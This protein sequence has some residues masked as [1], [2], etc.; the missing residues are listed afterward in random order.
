[1]GKISKA[2][3]YLLLISGCVGFF[4]FPKLNALYLFLLLAAFVIALIRKRAG[5]DAKFLTIM[6]ICIVISRIFLSLIVMEARGER[7]TQDE[8]LYSKKAIIKVY[9]GRGIRDPEESFA[10]FFDD[11]DMMNP[12]YG[13]NAY[14]CILSGFYRIFGYQIQ[15]ARLIN[16]FFNILTFLLIFYMART[17]FGPR[18]AKLSSAIFAFFPSVTLWSVSIGTDMM[19]LL[20]IS[21]Y[22][23][24]LIRVLKKIDIMSVIIMIAALSVLISFRGYAV[25]ILV[26]IT[27]FGVFCF[28]L[29]RMTAP[30][31]TLAGILLILSI[32]LIA[33]ATPA[34]SLVKN[35]MDASLR[36]VIIRQ[37]GFAT[38]DEG[39]YLVYP[40]H[41]YSDYVCHPQDLAQAYAKGMAYVLFSPF[42][43]K[44]NSKLQLAAYPQTILWYFM[45]PVVVYGFYRGFRK[46]WLPT[47]LIF[48]YCFL[49][50]SALAL[51]QGNVGG[52][53]RHKDMVLPFTL[54]YFAAGLRAL[55]DKNFIG[56]PA[57]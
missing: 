48:L 22:L 50:F 46:E 10:R 11:V 25:F 39:G 17:L 19:A 44:I 56:R 55:M 7:L 54:I 53:F 57:E 26:F 8:G 31:R 34:V 3:L 38:I 12:E 42:P 14:T 32:V 2:G 52:L 23:F 18:V 35:K 20:C 13:Y 49:F 1:M 4:L 33:C 9:E 16:G 6:I 5:A 36:D 43:W 51:V 40:R 45:L 27:A 41:C 28:I 21:A 30:G 29:K 37:A 15:A 47:A 24:S